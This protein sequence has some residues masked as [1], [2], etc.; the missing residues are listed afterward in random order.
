MKINKKIIYSGALVLTSFI[1]GIAFIWVKSALNAGMDSS[2]LMFV[3]YTLAA[4]VLF[5]FCA[6]GLFKLSR[7]QMVMGIIMGV[8][9]YAGMIVQTIALNVT[10]P[11]NSAFITTSYVVITPF[12]TWFMLRVRP[13]RKIYFCAVICLIGI[14]I[15]TRVPG[16]VFSISAGDAL[17]LVAALLFA[18][19]MTL[20]YRFAAFLPT[21]QITFIPLVVTS[22]LSL[23]TAAATNKL[24][25]EGVD[26]AAC[27]LPI[28]LVAVCSTVIAGYLQAFGQ[29]HVE[30]SRAAIILSLESVFA[31]VASVIMGFD[32]LTLS[33]VVGGTIIVSTIIVSEWPSK[34]SNVAIECNSELRQHEEA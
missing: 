30:P 10:T 27:I 7:K 34:K 21:K 4:L 11:S 8:A 13:K 24:S 15:L 29:K 17:T 20:L 6:K 26:I 18:V 31:C 12:V 19:Q 5:P 28:T 33:L 16:E 25:F 9:L 1:W 22:V 14:F 23:I 3:R 32:K 2:L